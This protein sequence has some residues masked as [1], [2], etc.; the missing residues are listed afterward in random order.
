M[1]HFP[2]N[3][4]NPRSEDVDSYNTYPVASHSGTVPHSVRQI[5]GFGHAAGHPT[6]H[7]QQPVVTGTSVLGI[8]YKGGVMM[9][10]DN[11]ASYGSLAR[12]RD[13]ERLHKV[14]D[15]TVLGASG[16]MSDYQYVKHLLDSQM[17]KE[18]NA[19]D[20][21][22]LATPNIYEYLWRVMY[23]RRSK[24]NPLWN[25]FVL[26]GV[27]KGESFLGA[28]DL[29]GTP[30]QSPSIATGF[31][32]H[33]AQP[34]LRK[35]IENRGGEENITQE[36]AAQILKKC[37]KVLFYRDARSMNK[38]QLARISAEGVE[39]SE[40]MSVETEWAFAEKIRGYGA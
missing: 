25:T 6:S 40:P 29:K 21:H 15:F 35:E 7:T 30:Y 9:A 37:M 28:I 23:N 33:L 31:G 36:D 27:H 39:I 19:D 4:G 26:G 11:L 17:I 5:A 22:T 16:D 3:W 20:G 24:M 13:V 18:Y 32:S 1:D 14:A 10:A 38:F 8:K 2:T 34:I 12:F